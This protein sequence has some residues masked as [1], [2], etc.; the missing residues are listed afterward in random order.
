MRIVAGTARGRTLEAPKGHD[1]IRPTADRVRETIFNVLGQTC[2]GLTVLDL[3]AG[4]GALGLEAISRG[5][6]FAVLVDQH[7]LSLDLCR[8]NT[9]TLKFDDRVEIISSPVARVWPK[10]TAAPRRFDLVFADPPYAL[11]AGSEV[12]KHVAA[13]MNPG[14]RLVLESGKTE[15]PQPVD[16]LTLTDERT[17][18]DT[19]VRIYALA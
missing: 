12:L 4:T 13:L 3:F 15:V 19:V 10:L 14:A 1:I 8:Q 6:V 18:G 16:A 5:A 11:E 17:F 9:A 7:R 2:D